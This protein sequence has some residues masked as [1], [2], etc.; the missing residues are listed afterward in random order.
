M[1]DHQEEQEM[2]AEALEAIFMDAFEVRSPSQ[3]FVWSVKLMPVDCGGDE[4]EENRENHVMVNLI[5]T[6]PLTYPEE[7]L[8]ELDIE[9]VKGLSKDNKTELVKL[10]NEEAEANEGM[11]AVFAVCE[12]IKEWLVD[13]NVKGLDDAS[14]HAQM[15]RKA[16]EKERKEVSCAAKFR[17]Q[18]QAHA[19]LGDVDVFNHRTFIPPSNKMRSTCDNKFMS[20]QDPFVANRTEC[21]RRQGVIGP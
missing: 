9:V 3:P 5:A 4:E 21:S 20:G 13:N 16:K 15:M 14:M 12:R 18:R 2:E 17:V 8:P 1:S 19:S 11:P 10:A 7:T 6:I